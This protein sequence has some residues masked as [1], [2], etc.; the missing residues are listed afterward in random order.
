MTS[1]WVRFHTAE[2]G[3]GPLEVNDEYCCSSGWTPD[4]STIKGRHT[5]Q[6]IDTR[7]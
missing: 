3:G 1:S 5:E 6:V 2:F 4:V 7:D